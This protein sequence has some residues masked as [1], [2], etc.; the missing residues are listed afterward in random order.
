MWAGE[1]AIPG[2][3]GRVDAFDG[4]R[5]DDPESRHDRAGREAAARGQVQEPREGEVQGLPGRPAAS[6]R[7]PQGPA[8]G[9]RDRPDR[10][11]VRARAS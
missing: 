5:A 8:V 6:I 7:G 3:G 11:A 1:G 2:R 4:S 10:L 9:Q